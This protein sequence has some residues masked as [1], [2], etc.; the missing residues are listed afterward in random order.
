M[1]I[2]QARIA[3]QRCFVGLHRFRLALHVVEEHAEVIEQHR[4]VAT[5]SD[6]LAI[7]L[8]GLREAPGF[9]QKPPQVDMRIEERRIR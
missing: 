8:L 5:G 3:A 9:V 7:D 2:G 6:R 4:I 1:A